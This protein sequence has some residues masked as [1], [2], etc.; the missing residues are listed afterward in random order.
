MGRIFQVGDM[1]R[2][3]TGPIAAGKSDLAEVAILCAVEA[4][5]TIVA[6]VD[7]RLDLLRF[8][9][10]DVC[11][12]FDEVRAPFDAVVVTDV[13]DAMSSF[14]TASAVCGVERVLVPALLGLK[15]Q[16]RPA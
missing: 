14:E 11:K 6:V 13:A 10:V 9:G 15:K 8:V 2:I 1:V 3:L 5:I 7:P 4:G 12:A 16:G